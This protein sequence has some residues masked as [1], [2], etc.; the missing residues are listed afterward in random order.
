MDLVFVLKWV[1][2]VIGC[3]KSYSKVEQMGTLN[4]CLYASSIYV[5]QGWLE[6][7]HTRLAGFHPSTSSGSSKQ[8]TLC[9]HAKIR[10][11]C[12]LYLTIWL[13]RMQAQYIPSLSFNLGQVHLKM[14][15][16]PKNLNFQRERSITLRRTPTTPRALKS[17]FFF[18]FIVLTNLSLNKHYINIFQIS[19]YVAIVNR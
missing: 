15:L 18:Y 14:S 4:F 1:K 8:A 6:L 13:C 10:R 5:I 17:S 19:K 2:S 12:S 11:A 3:T 9:I 16:L 7:R